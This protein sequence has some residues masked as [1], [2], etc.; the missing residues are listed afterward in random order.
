M[1]I[2]PG[3]T[4]ICCLALSTLL[5]NITAFPPEPSYISSLASYFSLQEASL[6]P[7]CIIFP[8]STNDVSIAVKTLTSLYVDLKDDGKRQCQFAIRSGGHTAWA[9]AA[10]I[11]GGVTLDLRKLNSVHVNSHR[12]TVS[13]GAGGSWDLV[14]SKLDPL[15][16]S[17]N[18]GRTAG[19]GIGGLSTGGGISYFGTR[20]GWTADAIINYEVVLANGTVVNANDYEHP[21]LLWALRGGS[22]NFGIV[23]SIEMQTFPQEPFF[24]GYA[25]YK[26]DVWLEEVHEFVKINDPATYDEFA[27]LTLTWGFSATTGLIV[28]NQLE[29][30]KPEDNPSIFANL[31]SLP[32]LLS[33]GG[34]SNVTQ[35]SRDLRSQAATGQ[36]MFWSTLTFLSTEA[37]INATFFRFNESSLAIGEIPGIVSSLTLEPLPPVLYARNRRSNALGFDNR[38]NI[39]NALVIALLSVSYTSPDDD[40]LVEQYGRSL[41]DAINVDMI[42]LQAFDPF[43]YLNYAAPYQNPLLSYTEPNVRRL[44]KI[45]AE[46]DPLGTFQYQ[47]PGG[48]KLPQA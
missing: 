20:Y 17:V 47:V 42:K 16:R 9:G 4:G 22:N 2:N 37:A 5:G 28:A 19:V 3:T 39:T 8:E 44:R 18:G 6:Q 23:T 10:N 31:R 27:H 13:V 32:A 7:Q 41:M 40:D 11:D 21:D 33:V 48:F 38:G 12:E 24:G 36:R 26:P 15:D 35:L 43:L 14:Y 25:Y 45:A 29:Y 30:T 1:T 46:Q 34:I